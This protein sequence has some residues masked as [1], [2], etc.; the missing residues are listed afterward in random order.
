VCSSDL[1]R[2]FNDAAA[3]VIK[4]VVGAAEAKGLKARALVEAL[5][6]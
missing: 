3:G 5:S 4:E 6:K 2:A 1:A